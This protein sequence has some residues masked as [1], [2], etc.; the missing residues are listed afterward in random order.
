MAEIQTEIAAGAEDVWDARI[1]EGRASHLRA[2]VKAAKELQ[3]RK[4]NDE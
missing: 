2:L 3:R 1:Q 4:A